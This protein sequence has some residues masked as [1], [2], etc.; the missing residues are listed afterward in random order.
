MGSRGTAKNRPTPAS[1]RYAHVLCI[2]YVSKA[3]VKILS[4]H[5][6]N[7]C[8]ILLSMSFERIITILLFFSK[9]YSNINTRISDYILQLFCLFCIDLNFQ[10]KN[11]KKKK[12]DESLQMSLRFLKFEKIYLYDLPVN[13]T[14]NF[15]STK[16]S[17]LSN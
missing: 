13:K 16:K 10:K 3:M 7:P 15:L 5:L 17:N 9:F 1:A 8:E 4:P 6:E 12:Y 2:I 11:E 14:F